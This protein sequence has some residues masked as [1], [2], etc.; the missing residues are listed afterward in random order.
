MHPDSVPLARAILQYLTTHTGQPLP[1][2]PCASTVT[3]S[4]NSP[5]F[6]AV[7]RRRPGSRLTAP[8]AV[9]SDRERRLLEPLVPAPLPGG[10]PV[11]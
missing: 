9:R 3:T 4:R 7:S 11:S 5:A 10:R 8:Y 2:R 1:G 6:R